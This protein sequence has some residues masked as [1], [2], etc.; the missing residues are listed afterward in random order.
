M[1]DDFK[2]LNSF[3]LSQFS[4]FFVLVLVYLFLLWTSIPIRICSIETSEWEKSAEKKD[5]F[6]SSFF[7]MFSFNLQSR[8]KPNWKKRYLP[9]RLLLR[10]KKRKGKVFLIIFD[11]LSITYA[12]RLSHQ[13]RKEDTWMEESSK[14]LSYK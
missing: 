7:Q 12:G 2:K 3:S 1:N 4:S 13:R 5:L 6:S 9:T 8:Q 14:T 10:E 11:R